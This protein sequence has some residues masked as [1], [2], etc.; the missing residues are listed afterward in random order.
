ME[1]MLEESA[2]SVLEVDGLPLEETDEESYLPLF[3]CGPKGPSNFLSDAP[4]GP[5][6]S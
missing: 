2:E 4:K 5:L 6:N 1:N 3:E